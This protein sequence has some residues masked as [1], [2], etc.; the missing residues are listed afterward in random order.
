MSA[1]NVEFSPN[2]F[3]FVPQAVGSPSSS[4]KH[5]VIKNTGILPLVITSATITGDDFSFASGTTL[6]IGTINPGA[7]FTTVLVFRAT[8][9]GLLTG[10]LTL[11]DN[12]PG[13]PHTLAIS[14]QGFTGA[15]IQAPDQDDGILLATPTIGNGVSVTET[16]ISS[17]TQS[18]TVTG[19]N[20]T[21]AGFSQSNTCGSGMN[22]G[23]T[24]DVQVTFNPTLAGSQSGTLLVSN[25]GF[26][27]P[28][29]IPLSGNGGDF[30]IILAPGALGSA[31]VAAGQV[32]TFQL[33]LTS[34][35]NL[36]GA[37]TGIAVTCSNLP[38][39]STC[40]VTQTPDPQGFFTAV[41]IG[42]VT[43][44]HKASSTPLLPRLPWPV[45]AIVIT[46]VCVAG[47]SQTRRMALLSFLLVA[48]CV[49]F[50]IS[51]GTN[52]SSSSSGGTVTPPG[53]Y[54]VTITATRGT[55]THTFTL[56]LTV[57]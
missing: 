32:A 18:V 47:R 31:T 13:S 48:S 57:Q 50:L 36:P 10:T 35:S 2:P 40:N 11:Q 22:P 17:G 51:C 45:A 23:S 37:T 24:C 15:G 33:H 34:P 43:T 26:V 16:I 25:T 39:A 38:P 8:T 29:V 41:S 19:V 3:T 42:V 53:S 56:N 5:L 1:Q 6:N 52:T 4:F 49:G 46:M 44:G 12:A 27:S 21:G 54:T 9:T 20:V 28:L 7:T 55:L 14:S 30:S